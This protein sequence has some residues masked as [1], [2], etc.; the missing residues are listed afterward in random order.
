[1]QDLVKKV[2][3]DLINAWDDQDFTKARKELN[4][5]FWI[6]RDTKILNLFFLMNNLQLQSEIQP[7]MVDI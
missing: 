7:S 5:V 2:G 1:M 6:V 4:S 3:D